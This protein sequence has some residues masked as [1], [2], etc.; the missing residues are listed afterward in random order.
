MLASES[1]WPPTTV[2]FDHG[3][4]LGGADQ[5]KRR[6]AMRTRAV[7]EYYIEGIRRERE[8]ARENRSDASVNAIDGNDSM[9]AQR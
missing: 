4:R 5:E 3:P 1:Q 2:P 9:V 7:R 6:A 8:R